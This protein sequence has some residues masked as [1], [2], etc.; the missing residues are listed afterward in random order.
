MLNLGY[1]H[2]R[3]E[4]EKKKQSDARHEEQAS[5]R[6]IGGMLLGSA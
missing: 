5:R 4:Y 3:D 1:I 2:F 6:R